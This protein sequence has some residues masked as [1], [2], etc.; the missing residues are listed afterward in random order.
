MYRFF[1]SYNALVM[2]MNKTTGE[3]TQRETLA[4]C[5]NSSKKEALTLK[6][7]MYAMH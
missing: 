4:V 1:L 5:N 7:E 2:K 3:I 6:P